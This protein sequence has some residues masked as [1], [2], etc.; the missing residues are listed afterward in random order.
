MKL[1]VGKIAQPFLT[2]GNGTRQIFIYNNS[3]AI[4]YLG[5]DREH[6]TPESGVPIPPGVF[7]PPFLWRG[8]LWISCDVDNV[9]VV[10]EFSDQIQYTIS[11]SRG[12]Q[13]FPFCNDVILG[14]DLY[15]G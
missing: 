1:Q 14:S 7:I 4:V 3:G 15:R 6:A 5:R 11:Q 12:E 13:V 9:F 2:D 8:V 10:Y